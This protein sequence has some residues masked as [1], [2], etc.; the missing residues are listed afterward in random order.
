LRDYGIGAQIL[1]DLGLKNIR[2]L[3]NNPRK[4][5]GLEGYGLHVIERVPLEIEPNPMNYKYL[6]TKK[7]KLGHDLK[8]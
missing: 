5:V 4:I 2:L 1:A 6:K 8:I 3:T 7:E